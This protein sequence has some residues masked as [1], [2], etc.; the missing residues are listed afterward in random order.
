MTTRLSVETLFCTASDSMA[1]KFNSHDELEFTVT[2]AMLAHLTL[3]PPQTS[4]Q[5][6]VV[7]EPPKPVTLTVVAEPP[8][9]VTL[10][11]VAEP[12]KPVT[13]AKGRGK[14]TKTIYVF[15][16]ANIKEK[17]RTA[18]YNA[19][20]ASCG[21]TANALT[22]GQ[23]QSLACTVVMPTVVMQ[24]VDKVSNLKRQCYS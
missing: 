3:S 20:C 4:T 2:D 16:S 19:A 24:L 13:K 17:K 15:H 18:W 21:F 7:S 23:R 9:P 22:N 6:T 8:K 12:P 11:V 10:I 5:L 1:E 14:K